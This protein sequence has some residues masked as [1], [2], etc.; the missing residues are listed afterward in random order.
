MTKYISPQTLSIHAYLFLMSMFLYTQNVLT[1][2]GIEEGF[3]HLALDS[4]VG[5][6]DLFD[7]K[8]CI[9]M[10]KAMSVVANKYHER[11]K[12]LEKELEENEK[13]TNNI[14]Y[15]AANLIK[16]IS[17]KFEDRLELKQLE[18]ERKY[19]RLQRQLLKGDHKEHKEGNNMFYN[20]SSNFDDVLR[21]EEDHEQYVDR[22]IWK[23]EA[24]LEEEHVANVTEVVL[25]TKIEYIK[26]C[27]VFL[28][29]LMRSNPN[30]L[31]VLQ[32][33][34]SKASYKVR[35]SVGNQ[36]KPYNKWVDYDNWK[37]IGNTIHD[38]ITSL[39]KNNK[40]HKFF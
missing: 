36:R 14:Q 7:D 30:K 15:E 33:V 37:V 39:Q 4:S 13:K 5:C 6:S 40:V 22:G 11:L 32:S 26:G 17:S 27:K 29:K 10:Q 1:S 8:Q 35:R 16:E 20:K 24:Y 28:E 21:D 38:F 19:K 12:N 18:M 31:F 23:N 34:V 25:M 3:S 9:F 2:S